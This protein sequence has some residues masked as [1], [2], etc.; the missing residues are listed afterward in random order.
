MG[1]CRG[2][3]KEGGEE[4][5]YVVTQ[6]SKS[7]CRHCGDIH[8]RKRVAHCGC[9]LCPRCAEVVAVRQRKQRKFDEKVRQTRNLVM[10][11]RKW[12]RL[13]WEGLGADTK[14]ARRH[15]KF[16]RRC[17]KGRMGHALEGSS[18]SDFSYQKK[19]HPK[20]LERIRES[21]REWR[22]IYS[23]DKE[24]REAL[25]LSDSESADSGSYGTEDEDYTDVKAFDEAVCM[26]KAAR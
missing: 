3:Q 21:R 9:K 2:R 12:E 13:R 19:T 6:L 22:R 5:Q 26:T 8:I 23:D 17:L 20:T 10:A 25:A 4:C 11:K 15:Y 16:R 18:T 1:K 7:G 14:K 24:F